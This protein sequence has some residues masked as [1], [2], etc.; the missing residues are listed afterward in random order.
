M[1]EMAFTD[2]QFKQFMNAIDI[3]ELV[4]RIDENTKNFHKNFEDHVKQDHENYAIH[5]ASLE[6]MHVRID[7][8]D[9]ENKKA[10][11]LFVGGLTVITV[12]VGMIQFAISFYFN[13]IKQ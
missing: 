10:K 7:G 2:E 12:L 5:K 9:S 4:I 1:S 13:A 3:K 6:K 11:N 8:L